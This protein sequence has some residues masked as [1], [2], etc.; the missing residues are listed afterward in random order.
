[1]PDN[2]VPKL[3]L[4]NEKKTQELGNQKKTLELG[5]QN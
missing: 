1:L 2:N 5:N 4:G 3:E